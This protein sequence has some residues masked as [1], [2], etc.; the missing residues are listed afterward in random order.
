MKPSLIFIIIICLLFV[1]VAAGC[2]DS[3]SNAPEKVSTEKTAASEQPAQQT[4]QPIPGSTVKQ[5]NPTIESQS[6]ELSS[7]GGNLTVHFLD[8]GQG[9]SILLEHDDDTAY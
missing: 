4:E 1:I 2:S 5:Q 6:K 9:D 3:K 8:V 7:A